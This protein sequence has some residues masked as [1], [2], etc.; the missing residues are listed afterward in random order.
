[1][2]KIHFTR[3]GRRFFIAVVLLGLAS[4]NTGNNLVYL[5]FSMMLAISIIA[6]VVAVV[7]LRGLAC[8][9][10]FQEPLYA[11]TP[12]KG[13]VLVH[14]KKLLPSYSVSVV[15]PVEL[16]LQLYF[17]VVKG[18]VSRLSFDDA[19]IG[20]RG[21]YYFRDLRLRTGFPFIFMYV[22]RTFPYNR[23]IIIYPRIIDVSSLLAP[24][25][26]QV[27][28]RE[29]LKKGFEGDFLFSREY[30]YGEESRNIDWK[31]TARTQKAMVREYS[32]RDERFVTV[33][34]DNGGGADEEAFEKA[35]SISASICSEFIEKDFYVRLVTCGKIVPFGIGRLHLF[36]IL[37]ILAGVK[38]QNLQDCPIS[39]SLEGL[40]ILVTCSD[41]SSFSRII[42]LCS[43]VID[44]R[45]L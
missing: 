23:E 36:K 7:N 11:Q 35:V 38:E 6:F 44:A 25:Q 37:D 33:I 17:P 29:T 28:E 32:S 22:Y 10:E 40:N 12:F 41:D 18:K 15:I 31:A 9:V 16:S 45:N 30:L 42:P 8:S 21:K 5:L 26:S 1:M 2:K 13:T 3:E 24:I 34:L 43:G 14:S 19:V 39:E 4:L 27:L 20:R